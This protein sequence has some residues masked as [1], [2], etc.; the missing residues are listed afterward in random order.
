MGKGGDGRGERNGKGKG[1]RGWEGKGRGR[2]RGGERE[3]GAFRQIKIYDY[4]PAD[5]T[6][7]TT[8]L[9]IVYIVYTKQFRERYTEAERDG[10]RNGSF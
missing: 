1:K 6:F 10:D 9:Y 8:I 7:V 3:G 2:G 5:T 4:T